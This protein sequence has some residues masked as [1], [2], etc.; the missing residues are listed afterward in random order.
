MLILTPDPR[1]IFRQEALYSPD[2]E[3][4]LIPA[5]RLILMAPFTAAS[6]EG[7]ERQVHSRERIQPIY[8]QAQMRVKP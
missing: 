7:V 2:G 8:N 1:N 4:S 3:I 6:V 5:S